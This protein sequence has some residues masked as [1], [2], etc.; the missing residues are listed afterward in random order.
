MRVPQSIVPVSLLFVLALSVFHRILSEYSGPTLP[1]SSTYP[2]ASRGLDGPW[3]CRAVRTAAPGH[4]RSPVKLWHPSGL[5]H[6]GDA[7]VAAL[8]VVFCGRLSDIGNILPPFR[9][10]HSRASRTRKGLGGTLV[11]ALRRR[12]P[13]GHIKNGGMPTLRLLCKAAQYFPVPS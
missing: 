5:S 9:R 6:K 1:D 7:H 12:G 4:D 2:A 13:A 3:S 11:L 10:N 8:M